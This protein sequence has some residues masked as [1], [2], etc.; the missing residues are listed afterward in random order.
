MLCRVS[1]VKFTQGALRDP[2]Q[3][4]FGEDSEQLPANVQSLID[5]AVFIRT[6]EKIE[7]E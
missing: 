5:S 7:I 2:L 3:H 6:L 1:W 4:L